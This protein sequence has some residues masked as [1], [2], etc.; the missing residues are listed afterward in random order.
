MPVIINFLKLSMK[1]TILFASSALTRFIAGSTFEFD[2]NFSANDQVNDGDD[3]NVPTSGGN[4]AVA[5]DPNT[6]ISLTGTTVVRNPIAIIR[7]G[8]TEDNEEGFWLDGDYATVKNK[9]NELFLEVNL[10]LH[11]PGIP[12]KND[13]VYMIWLQVIDPI[14]SK[15][16]KKPYYEG[17]SCSIRYD[18]SIYKATGKPLIRSNYLDRMGYKGE[19]SLTYARG[20]Y[21]NLLKSDQTEAHAWL[22]QP[23]KTKLTIDKKKG[24]YSETCNMYRDFQ[25]I[26]SDVPLQNNLN[27]KLEAGFKVF[28]TFESNGALWMGHKKNVEWLIQTNSDGAQAT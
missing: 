2:P 3:D 6:S 10:T 15:E 7:Y 19:N 23:G 24:V 14:K 26:Y 27:L 18:E 9:Y 5:A 22:L 4:K 8:A 17:F 13:R 28:D 11:H 1:K 20:S 21:K 25:T 16:L 12:I